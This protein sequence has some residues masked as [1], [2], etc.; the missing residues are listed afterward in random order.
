M[1]LLQKLG[2]RLLLSCQLLLLLVN[3]SCPTFNFQFI[4]L[5]GLLGHINLLQASFFVGQLAQLSNSQQ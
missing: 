2:I 4:K 1:L 3:A 5:V